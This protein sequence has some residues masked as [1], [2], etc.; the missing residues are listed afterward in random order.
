VFQAEHGFADGSGF[1]AFLEGVDLI[2]SE[3]GDTEPVVWTSSEQLANECQLEVKQCSEDESLF[4]LAISLD[5]HEEETYWDLI[6]SNYNLLG[7]HKEYSPE[8]S[9]TTVVHEVCIPKDECVAF[10][11]H[12][13]YGDGSCCDYGD[14]GY[15]I[16]LDGELYESGDGGFGSKIRILIGDSCPIHDTCSGLSYLGHTE[17]AMNDDD[18]LYYDGVCQVNPISCPQGTSVLVLEM[19][20][21]IFPE[22]V[23]WHLYDQQY[24]LIVEKTRY[25]FEDMLKT[26]IHQMCVPDDQCLAFVF[27]DSI[28]DGEHEGRGYVLYLDGEEVVNRHESSVGRERDNFGSGCPTTSAVTI[29]INFDDF[30]QET[31]WSIIDSSGIPVIEVFAHTYTQEYDRMVYTFQLVEG[32]VFQ[33]S[34]KDDNDNGIC[35]AFGEGNYGIYLGDKVDKDK[36][37]VAGN[38]RFKSQIT[39][40][41]L[42]SE[43]GLNN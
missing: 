25:S 26:N 24:N 34:M 9:A 17:S 42:N 35:C 16:W 38:G 32:E 15:K 18:A 33:F 19:T 4:I 37:L 27:E 30:P 7:H 11:L 36:Q 14:G 1:A 5:R 20:Q 39:Q 10:T 28:G 41:F 3:E 31:G 29:E 12:D 6:D 43:K 22:E 21:D 23:V 2:K 8:L 40:P 13:S